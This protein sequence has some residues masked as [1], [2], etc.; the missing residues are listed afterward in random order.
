MTHLVFA[1]VGDP[2]GHSRSPAIH[3]A[4]LR[5]NG[6]DGSYQPRRAGPAQMARIIEEVRS[7]QLHGVN[8]TMPNK[9][10]AAGL[11]DVLS[12]G[13]R[14][15]GAVNTLWCSRGRV[16]GDNTDSE[17]VRWAWS[18]GRLPRDTPVMILGAGGAAAAAAL[19]LEGTD[20]TI[21]ARNAQRAASLL[22]DTGVTGTVVSWGESL[23]GVAIINAT[24]IGMRG[25]TLPNAILDRAV[26][27][28][29]MTYGGGQTPAVEA[30]RARGLPAVGGEYMLVGQAAAAFSRWTGAVA[31]F[32]VMLAAVHS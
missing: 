22:E 11:A 28:L 14:R 1:V 16:Y 10:V 9:R 15:A 7:Y 23:R 3:E 2:I 6:I 31:P 4:A 8:V 30:M 13:A 27:L 19:A 21:S 25:E 18:E 24:P 5:W 17:G 20:L 29:D 26:G 12:D 32:D